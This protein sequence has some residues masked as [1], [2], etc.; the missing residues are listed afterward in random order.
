MTCEYKEIFGKPREGIHNIR[1]FDLAIV[2]I[3]GTII[4][5]LL[6]AKK[7]NYDK[8]KV[9]GILFLMGIIS[10]RLFCVKTTVDKL[11]FD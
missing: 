10:H 6:I 3:I 2:D 8:Y 4:I 7:F 11:L 1:L 5:G 9:I